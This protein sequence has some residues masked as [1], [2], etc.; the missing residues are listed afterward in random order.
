[1]TVAAWIRR[2]AQRHPDKLAYVD[3]ERRYTYAQYVD[4]A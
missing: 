1:M 4:R 2:C 3:G